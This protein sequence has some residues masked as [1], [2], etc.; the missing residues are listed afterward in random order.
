[1][2]VGNGPPS[3]RKVRGTLV[4]AQGAHYARKI[5]SSN[6]CGIITW[7]YSLVQFQSSIVLELRCP[8]TPLSQLRN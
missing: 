2:I 5:V 1:M 8:F 4:E 3:T 7:I 6:T